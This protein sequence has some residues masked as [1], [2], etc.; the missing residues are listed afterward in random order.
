MIR[1]FFPE[2]NRFDGPAG[3]R[4]AWRNAL[5][6]CVLMKQLWPYVLAFVW[7][8]VLPLVGILGYQALRMYHGQINNAH[9]FCL[10]FVPGGLAPIGAMAVVI[11]FPRSKIRKHLRRQLNKLGIP[12]CMECGYDLAGNTSGVRPECGSSIEGR[13]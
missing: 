6:E 3:R 13:T 9:E 7:F 4:R 1:L 10:A 12:T 11:Y 5:R 8:F 2:L